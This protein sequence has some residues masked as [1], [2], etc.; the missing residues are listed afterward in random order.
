MTALV[1]TEVQVTVGVDTHADV[2]VAAAL[3]QL[4]RVL[5]TQSVPS[6]PAGYRAL[7]AWANTL[8][9]VGRFG[10][11]GTSSYGAGLSRWLRSR[12][13]EV[14]EVECPKRRNRRHSGKS[15]TIDAEAAARAVQAGTATGQPKAGDGPIEMLRM[16]QAARRSAIKARTQA[17]NQLHALVVTAPDSLRTR[18]RGLS[19]P[20]L[21]AAAVAFR[22]RLPLTSTITATQLV[23][24]SLAVRHEQLTAEIEALEAQLELLVAKAA[25]DLV[26]VKGIGTDIATTLLATAGDNPDRLRC[27]GAFAHLCGVAP[28]PASSGKTNRHRL[29]RGGDRDANRALYLLAV[30]RM[31]WDPATR[32][33]VER[34]TTEGLSKKEILR[35]L[36]RY[37]ARELYPLLAGNPALQTLRQNC[38]VATSPD[39]K[40]D[41]DGHLGGAA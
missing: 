4:G 27:E 41:S 11:E 38:P 14:L 36:K 19:R 21:V 26:A 13:V 15:D 37:I 18:L 12:G 23:L 39:G 40:R 20:R 31:G 3:D 28:I 22:P 5:A 2:H 8:G 16:L 34:R 9:T 24:K 10:I 33:Y 7:V 32:A 30:G 35:C 6:T 25:P 17:A 29:N 1:S